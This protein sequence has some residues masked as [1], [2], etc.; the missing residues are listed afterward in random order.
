MP[1]DNPLMRRDPLPQFGAIRAEHVLPAVTR[2][3]QQNRDQ[4]DSLL[5]APQV[6][7]K[8]LVEPLEDSQHE[9]ARVWS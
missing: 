5:A 3:L 2:L 1:T 4:L 8:S 9:L 7:F 6:T